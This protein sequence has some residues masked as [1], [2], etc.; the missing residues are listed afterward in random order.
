MLDPS[1]FVAVHV[2]VALVFAAA[3]AGKFLAPAQFRETLRDYRILPAWAVAP[4]ARALPVAETLVAACLP[5]PMLQPWPALAAG[6][7]L[8]V[9]AGAMAANLLRG[10]AQIDC[11]C[12]FA[13]KAGH[14]LRWHFVARNGAAAVLLALPATGTPGLAEW[15]TGVLGGV[16]LYLLLDA[17]NTLWALPAATP[18][19]RAS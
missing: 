7:L 17:A 10:R 11:G 19:A 18:S 4:V 5:F 8:V 2:G 1:A 12:S 13:A 9:F 15:V 14:R 3:A 6:M 16:T